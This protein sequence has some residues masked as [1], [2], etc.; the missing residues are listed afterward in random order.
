MCAPHYVRAL[1]HSRT[2]ATLQIWQIDI[3]GI[4]LMMYR[5]TLL[6]FIAILYSV[7]LLWI[8]EGEGGYVS[9]YEVD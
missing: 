2:S 8:D 9:T 7:R 4:M 5:V 1:L 6:P 3:G